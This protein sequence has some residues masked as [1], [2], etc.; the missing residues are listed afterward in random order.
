MSNA[1]AA[2]D[3]RLPRVAATKSLVGHLDGCDHGYEVG[4]WVYDAAKPDRVCLVQ[5]RLDGKPL[6][7]VEAG[8][9]RPDLRAFGI[10]PDCGFRITL[11]AGVFDGTLRSLELFAVPENARLGPA[12]PVVGVISD[13]K[14][15]PKRFSVDTILRAQDGAVD[16]DKV[17]P[18]EFLAVHG[19]RAAVA[20]AYLWLLKRPVDADGWAHYSEKI[21]ANEMTLGDLLRALNDSEECRKARRAGIDPVEDFVE[22]LRGA[23]KL[24]AREGN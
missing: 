4:G 8:L 2:L 16:F 3:A 24:R 15:Y 14:P 17:F 19:A 12:L 21:L 13:H 10:R 22:V 1:T 23:A 18:T 6:L 5:A 11:P 9:E 7:Q 20:Y